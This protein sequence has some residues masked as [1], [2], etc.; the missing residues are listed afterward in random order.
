MTV[1]LPKG[2]PKPATLAVARRNEKSIEVI[3]F[4]MIS[5]HLLNLRRI[6]LTHFLATSIVFAFACSD[7]TAGTFHVAPLRVD[8]GGISR[9][10][11]ITIRNDSPTDS[12][13]IQTRT[14]RWSQPDGEDVNSP[15]TDLIVNPPIFTLKPGGQQVLRVGARDLRLTASS[16]VELTYRLLLTEV[17]QA[18]PDPDKGIVMTLNLSV[19]VYFEPRTASGD[20]TPPKITIRR[21]DKDNLVAQIVNEGSRSI[22]ITNLQLVDRTTRALITQTEGF[23]HVLSKS[24]ILW[25]LKPYP[26]PISNVA[27]VV[28]SDRGVD[29]LEINT[30][31]LSSD[32]DSLRNAA[33]RPV[34]P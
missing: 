19:P 1:G 25:P 33:K 5:A 34:S 17:P 12:V 31:D 18:R 21:N 3:A 15:T 29:N 6:A 7:A 28:T 2:N 14:F 4:I 13:V 10:G 27:F 32:S 30:V 22:K 23:R 11:V 16:D 9:S 20:K 24:T 8:V 26:A